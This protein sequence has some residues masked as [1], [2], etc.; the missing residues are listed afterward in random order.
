MRHVVTK[1]NTP[2]TKPLTEPVLLILTS[3]A[4]QPRHGYALIQ[5]I[6]SLS[7]GRV[8]MSTG[9]L[10]G[11]LRRLLEDGWIE[12]FEQQDTS[13]QKQAY[14]LTAAGRKQLQLE[15]DRMKQLTRAGMARL[16]AAEAI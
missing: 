2:E 6:E 16:K 7:G 11:A 4:D 15:L 9:T 5:D 8:R 13:R 14:R 1:I 10:F 3:L 12:R